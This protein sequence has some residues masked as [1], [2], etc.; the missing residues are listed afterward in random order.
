MSSNLILITRLDCRYPYLILYRKTLTFMEI[1]F[2]SYSFTAARLQSHDLTQHYL[3]LK[4]IYIYIY[5]YIYGR[6]K[7]SNSN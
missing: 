4:P 7:I 1:K 5:I 3:T 6:K 2:P